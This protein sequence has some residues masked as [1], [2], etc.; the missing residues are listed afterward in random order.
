MGETRLLLFYP[1][2]DSPAPPKLGLHPK[3]I[4]R[5]PACTELDSLLI[6]VD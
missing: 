2:F 1:D 6:G 3:Q 4:G 5:A